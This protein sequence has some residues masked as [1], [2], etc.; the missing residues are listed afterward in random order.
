MESINCA[1]CNKNNFKILFKSRDYRYHLRGGEFTLVKCRSCG[2]VYLNPR[3]SKQEISK[4]YPQEYYDLKFSLLEKLTTQLFLKIDT[5]NLKKYKKG[6]LILDLGCG[7]GD[8][9]LE[10]KKCGFETIGVDVS[11]RACDIAQKRGIKVFNGELENCHF[12]DETFDIITLWHVFEHL[13]DPSST[14]KEIHRI[15]K[16]DG[17]LLIEVPN[18][19]SFSFKLFKRY[20]FHLDIP[21]HLYHWS[22]E[23]IEKILHQNK[24]RIFKKDYFS[25]AFPLSLFH[26]FHNFLSN[27]KFN[28]LLLPIILVFSPFL[29]C[30]TFI[31]RV[32]PARSE[33]LRIYARKC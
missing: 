28:F 7:P 31:S 2:L 9:L 17:I 30:L 6:G 24:I 1:V 12:S 15:M 10:M 4:F 25:L 8:F 22:P 5:A 11:K 29:F 3:P 13:H 16:K 14:L 27:Q 26:S 21:R 18:I 23:T 20:C 19:E 32:L 33:V